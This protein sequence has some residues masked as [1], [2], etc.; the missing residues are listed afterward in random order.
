[1]FG[2]VQRFQNFYEGGVGY[3]SV[4]LCFEF[5]SL[6]GNLDNFMERLNTFLI[7]FAKTGAPSLRNLLPTLSMPAAFAGF[8]S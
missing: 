8:I 4:F 7:G 1:M 6:F 2:F 5:R 3:R